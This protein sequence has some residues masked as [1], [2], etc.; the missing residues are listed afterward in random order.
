MP[1]G[2]APINPSTTESLLPVND[3]VKTSTEKTTTTSSTPVG[4]YVTET[5]TKTRSPTY[6]ESINETAQS[7]LAKSA[8]VDIGQRV[9]S[10]QDMR[11]VLANDLHHLNRFRRRVEAHE[12]GADVKAALAG[13]S[14]QEPDTGDIVVCD[15]V[16]H[17]TH[18]YHQTP[19]ST[20]V[21]STPA[22]P[23]KNGVASLL[24]GAALGAG[25]LGTGGIGALGIGSLLGLFDKTPA[26]ASPVVEIPTYRYRV[27]IGFENG[28]PFKRLLDENGKV[29]RELD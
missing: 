29:I 5:T 14:E 13:G 10:I 23:V 3:E 11:S 17:V 25:L 16:T 21:T 2:S 20:P 12:I 18:H 8:K 7:V 4:R 1:T 19:A 26:V 27:R 24:R 9:A 15:D 28:K 6:E 22:V